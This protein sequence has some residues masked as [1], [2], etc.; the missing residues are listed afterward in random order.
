MGAAFIA[1]SESTAVLASTCHQHTPLRRCFA[2][3][4]HFSHTMKQSSV[5]DIAVDW[6][7]TTESSVLAQIFDVS[8]RDYLSGSKAYWQGRLSRV[9]RKMVATTDGLSSQCGSCARPLWYGDIV[10]CSATRDHRLC[11]TCHDV[12]GFRLHN[13][14]YEQKEQRQH[15]DAEVI[16]SWRRQKLVEARTANTKQRRR[17]RVLEALPASV[18]AWQETIDLEEAR[19]TVKEARLHLE[20]AISRVERL[21]EVDQTRRREAEQARL[22]RRVRSRSEEES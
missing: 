17:Q 14:M 22:A 6:C 16:K 9:L 19:R 18:P 7:L 8:L 3:H 2:H 12:P 10:F 5:I 13:G 20:R 4:H 21:Q 11:P 1:A 15:S